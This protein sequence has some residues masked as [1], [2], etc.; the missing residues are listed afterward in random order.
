MRSHVHGDAGFVTR[1]RVDEDDGDARQS[2]RFGVLVGP[3]LELGFGDFVGFRAFH[4]KKNFAL[5]IATTC[6]QLLS[7]E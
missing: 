3:L 7:C 1:E 5:A 2:A 4:L 6:R